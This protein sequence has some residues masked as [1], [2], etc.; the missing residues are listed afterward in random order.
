MSIIIR[1]EL[2]LQEYCGSYF[3]ENG[4]S[5]GNANDYF[6]DNDLDLQ[7][8]DPKVWQSAACL[9]IECSLLSG[10]F[11]FCVSWPRASRQETVWRGGDLP[12]G[13]GGVLGVLMSSSDSHSSSN[14]DTLR[15]LESAGR[16]RPRLGEGERGRGRG[17][18]M[19]A[20]AGPEVEQAPQ[21]P[22]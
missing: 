12:E 8:L 14:S 15:V 7:N 2:K 5:T 11:K 19:L 20:S 17:S 3:T 22:P 6:K 21:T 13:D 10:G 4:I 9:T 16:G 18:C 1:I